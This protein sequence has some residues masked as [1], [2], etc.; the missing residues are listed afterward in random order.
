[1]DPARIIIAGDSAGGGLTLSTLLSLRENGIKLPAAAICL[2]TT[3]DLAQTG[4]SIRTKAAA[5]ALLSSE[6]LNVFYGNFL[7]TDGDGT[8]FVLCTKILRT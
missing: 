3:A 4:Q 2:S 8:F 6:L 7:G 1:M 5:D